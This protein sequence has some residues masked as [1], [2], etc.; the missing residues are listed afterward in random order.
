[1]SYTADVSFS[2]CTCPNSN[3]AVTGVLFISGEESSLDR[4]SLAQLTQLFLTAVLEC[5]FYKVKAP[6]RVAFFPYKDSS[7][8]HRSFKILLF[9][10]VSGTLLGRIIVI[11][12]E[13]VAPREPFRQ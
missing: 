1:M 7:P 2:H 10:A 13:L 12:L 4:L 3:I 9:C 5:P 8:P 6:V 11:P